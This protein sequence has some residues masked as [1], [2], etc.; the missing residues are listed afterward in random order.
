[1]KSKSIKCVIPGLFLALFSFQLQ[2]CKGN[3]DLDIQTAIASETQTNPNLAGVSAT[4]VNGVVTLSGQCKDEDCRKSAEKAVKKIDG[5]KDVTNN[6]IVT[7]AVT[8]TPDKELRKNAEKTISNYKNVQVGV[9]DGIITLRGEVKKD[10][11]QQLMMDL[12]GL[13]PKR[14]DNQLV[15]K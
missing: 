13:H 9:N 14:I 10:K 12:N 11:L 7:P 1:M 3:K 2:S 8:V 4:V 15:I 6:I 5:V